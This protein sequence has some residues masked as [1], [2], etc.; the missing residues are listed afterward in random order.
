MLIPIP[1]LA[2]TREAFI[3]NSECTEHQNLCRCAKNKK[4]QTDTLT[5]NISRVLNPAGPACSAASAWAS[6][7]K[8]RRVK[9]RGGRHPGILEDPFQLLCF[10]VHCGT[11]FSSPW[12]LRLISRDRV[13]SW[14]M[15]VFLAACCTSLV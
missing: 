1:K 15:T 3:I 6:F 14:T 2:G 12:N 8:M 11:S 5:L 10:G 4:A 7:R 13:P 9:G